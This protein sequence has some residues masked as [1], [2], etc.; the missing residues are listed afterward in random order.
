LSPF[1]DI[2]LSILPV[3]RSRSTNDDCS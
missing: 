3:I 2:S 1:S